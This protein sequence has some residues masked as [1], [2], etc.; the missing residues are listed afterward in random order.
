MN[1]FSRHRFLHASAATALAMLLPLQPAQAADGEIVVGAI[2]PITGPFAGAGLPYYNSLRMAQEDINAAGG[3]HG[4]KLR[5]AFEDTTANNSGAVN[6]YV[7]LVK[8]YNPPF[9]FL[10][11]LSTQVL[12]T[13]PEVA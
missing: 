11:S 3:I 10:S 12:A 8:Q 13:E 9:I 7:K 4:Q 6:A 2:V 1:A 5:I